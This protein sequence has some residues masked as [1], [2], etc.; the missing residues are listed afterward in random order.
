MANQDYVAANRRHPGPGGRLPIQISIGLDIRLL[1]DPTRQRKYGENSIHDQVGPLRVY[2]NAIWAH[3]CPTAIPEDNGHC[4]GWLNL[5]D[6]EEVFER[7]RQVNLYAKFDKCRFCPESVDYLGH[8]LTSTGVLPD[9]GKTN[10]VK[11]ARAPIN[12]ADEKEH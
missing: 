4:S 12:R 9:M 6:L 2:S 7:L 10:C 3:Q 11:N 8:Q 5:Q 1:A